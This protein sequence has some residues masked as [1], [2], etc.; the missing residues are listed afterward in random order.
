MARLTPEQ[1][2]HMIDHSQLVAQ[3]YGIQ[4]AQVGYGGPRGIW[5]ECRTC[6]RSDRIAGSSFCPEAELWNQFPAEYLQ[7][8]FRKHG[9]KGEGNAMMKAR[10]PDC[11]Q[12]EAADVTQPLA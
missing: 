1:I 3:N 7:D 6:L 8:V 9:W 12:K 10:C 11:S 5:L 2:Q 4:M